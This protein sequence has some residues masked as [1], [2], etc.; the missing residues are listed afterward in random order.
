MEWFSQKPDHVQ[1]LER[2]HG[3]C[4]KNGSGDDCRRWRSYY[5]PAFYVAV[6]CLST[7][8]MSGLWPVSGWAD[9]QRQTASIMSQN[10]SAYVTRHTSPADHRDKIGL[11]QQD[12][13]ENC[14]GNAFRGP[15]QAPYWQ[16]WTWQGSFQL[17]SM[18]RSPAAVWSASSLASKSSSRGP[19]GK[20][21]QS[22]SLSHKAQNMLVWK[23][24]LKLKHH[25][26]LQRVVK[27]ERGQCEMVS[28]WRMKLRNFP[29]K[30]K[31]TQHR[32][33]NMLKI[34]DMEDKE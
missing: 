6:A 12:I 17:R 26:L 10:G 16:L 14:Y 7:P 22:L 24:K 28:G 8:A 20:S 15:E 27:A 11:S 33:K 23:E 5:S 18:V 30:C 2:E 4:Y 21:S 1:G 32:D 13:W 25:K 31:W 29:R 34:I 19:V 9:I 3:L